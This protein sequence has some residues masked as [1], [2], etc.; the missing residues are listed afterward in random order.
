MEIQC[1]FEPKKRYRVLREFTHHPL[2]RLAVGEIVRFDS[3]MIVTVEDDPTDE[4]LMY[5]F[6]SEAHSV[7]QLWFPQP[8]E[9]IESWKEYFEEIRD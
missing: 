7:P 5:L 4:T 9:S 8:G 6:T 1:P 3:F 2:V